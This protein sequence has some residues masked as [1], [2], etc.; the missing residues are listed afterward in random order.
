MISRKFFFVF[1][2]KY[3][4]IIIHFV[5]LLGGGAHF[6]ILVSGRKLFDYRFN[7]KIN[8]VSFSPDGRYFAVC[9]IN[10]GNSFLL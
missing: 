5:C 9:K 6:I 4:I 2:F 3:G 10:K 1:N 8:S 7:G